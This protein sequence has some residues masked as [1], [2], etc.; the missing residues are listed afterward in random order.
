MAELQGIL[1]WAQQARCTAGWRVCMSVWFTARQAN[2]GNLRKCV[3]PIQQDVFGLEVHM[4]DL[5]APH[6][7]VDR[8]D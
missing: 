6:P 2:V 1:A 8:K 5:H 4:N 7:W 3:V